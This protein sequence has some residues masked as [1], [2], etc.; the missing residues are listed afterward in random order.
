MRRGAKHAAMQCNICGGTA[1]TDM[2]KRPAVRCAAC[3]S[4][5]R[6]RVAAL[7]VTEVLKPAPGSHILHF[8]PER[9][10]GALLRGIGG[11]NYRALDIDPARYPGLGVERFDLCE[12][13]FGLPLNR[14][15]LIVHNHVLE[16]LEGNYSAVLLRLARSLS[17][18]GTMLFSLPIL[19]GGFTDEIVVGS[20][21]EKLRRFGPSL[22]VRRFGTDTLQRT[23]GM[24]FPI[25][26]RYDLRD[27]FEEAVLTSCNIPPHHWTNF[28]G[29]TV[30]R[31]RK[32]DLRC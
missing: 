28:S 10:L 3:G 5:E 15:D 9:G 7:H 4:L 26:R 32:Q 6:T 11:P 20:P 23:L 14:Y 24:L 16:H 18:S 13:V 27:T 1:F 19:P 25:P 31:L 21:E 8:A 29:A 12:D 30:F 17:D 2:P 22:H